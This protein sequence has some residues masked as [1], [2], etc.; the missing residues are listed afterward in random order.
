MG[1][2]KDVNIYKNAISSFCETSIETSLYFNGFDI[3]DVPL[4]MERFKVEN[5]PEFFFRRQR[6]MRET[7]WG[8]ARIIGYDGGSANDE[9]TSKSRVYTQMGV[10]CTSIIVMASLLLSNSEGKF[11]SN[12]SSN[13]ARNVLQAIAKY[14]SKSS[15]G[16]DGNS[17]HIKNFAFGEFNERYCEGEDREAHLCYKYNRT[18]K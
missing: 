12:M 6:V 3:F 11:H 9:N 17:I 4:F 5:I 16:G 8:V 14:S 18:R 13:A 2:P 1:L 7:R 10:H 15:L